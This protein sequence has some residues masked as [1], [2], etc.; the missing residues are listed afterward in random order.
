MHYPGF[1]RIRPGDAM[2]VHVFVCVVHPTAVT[3]SVPCKNTKSYVTVQFL[4]R[5]IN[6]VVKH[7]ATFHILHTN[8]ILYVSIY[9]PKYPTP[10]STDFTSTQRG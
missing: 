5:L 7:Y 9:K 8:T 4:V 10:D 3:A 2:F 1:V 6:G